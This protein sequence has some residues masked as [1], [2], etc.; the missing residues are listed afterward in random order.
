MKKDADGAIVAV[1]FDGEDFE[2]LE[3]LVRREKLNRA[4]IIRRA[5]RELASRSGVVPPK[6]PKR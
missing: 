5:V 3:A 2:L 1:R 6:K 4:H